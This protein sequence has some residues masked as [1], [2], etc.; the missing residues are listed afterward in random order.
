MS[1]DQSCQYAS[2]LSAGH[3][4][5]IPA[6]LGIALHSGDYH[7]GPGSAARNAGV[8]AGVS[9]DIDGDPR[10]LGAGYDIGA[11][12]TR[13]PALVV[14]KQA[15]PT[16]VQAGER[17]TYTIR[18]TNTGDVDLHATISDTLP[19]HVS[20]SGVLT[21]TTTLP[22]PGGVWTETVVVT[23]EEGYAGPLTNVVE[24]TTLEGATGAYTH[25]TPAFAPERHFCYLP[26]VLKKP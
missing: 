20:P 2:F 8:D 15:N 23:V 9:T 6:Q 1:H 17:L 12:E 25:Q 13:Y 21:W 24:V 7:I 4:L 19:A 14:T 16:Q 3:P 10:P 11:D 5:P 26:L 18:V 22:A